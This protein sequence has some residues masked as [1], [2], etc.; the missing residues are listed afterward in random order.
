MNEKYEINTI[1]TVKSCDHFDDWFVAY[2]HYEPNTF[3]SFVEAMQLISDECMRVINDGSSGAGIDQY[4]EENH[5]EDIEEDANWF[6]DYSKGFWF[7]IDL[8]DEKF[9]FLI[10]DYDPVTHSI[11]FDVEPK[12]L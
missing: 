5:Q 12:S 3:D 10:L 8:D 9:L 7:N 4:I 2:N 1:Y 11:S 6:K